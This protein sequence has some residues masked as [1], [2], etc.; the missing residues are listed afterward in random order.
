MFY[1]F[2]ILTHV[3]ECDNLIK[4]ANLDKGA[5]MV[6]KNA[7]E[8]QLVRIQMGSSDVPSAIE[9]TKAQIE[10][11]ETFIPNMEPGNERNNAELAL[12]RLK[13]RL[14]NLERRAREV[15][16]EAQLKVSQD[17]ARLDAQIKALDAFI[18]GVE[19]RRGELETNLGRRAA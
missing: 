13:L 5:L 16:P 17:V 11:H 1:N 2:S 7:L 15:S 10:Q 9:F 3:G 6:R 19:E 4:Q 18:D 12:L 14:T 8:N